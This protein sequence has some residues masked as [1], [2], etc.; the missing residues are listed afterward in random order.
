[1][2]A[3]AVHG[4]GLLFLAE[5]DDG[6]FDEAAFEKAVEIGVGFDA[7]DEDDAVGFP[8]VAI[9]VEGIGK[10]GAIEFDDFHGGTD[11]AAHG[12]GGD[13]VG[14]EQSS[15]ALGGGAAVA[16]HGGNDEGFGAGGEEM[17]DDGLGDAIDIGDAAAADGDG[18]GGAGR[19]WDVRGGEALAGGGWD[20]RDVGAREI[21][22]DAVKFHSRMLWRIRRGASIVRS[23][24][25]RHATLSEDWIFFLRMRV[26]L[27]IMH[28]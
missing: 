24:V 15:L 6:H 27:S 25:L 21:L 1:V 23:E 8:G 26:I 3:E 20:V 12:G 4:V 22:A 28:P 5:A 19:N 18:N 11:G 2:D 9:H 17:I 14:F 13:V 10:T 7:V 16:A